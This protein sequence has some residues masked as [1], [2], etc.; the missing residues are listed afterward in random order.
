MLSFQQFSSNVS[1]QPFSAA[2]VVYNRTTYC[3]GGYRVVTF[4]AE[5]VV[6]HI[7]HV[8]DRSR[9]DFFEM[10][11]I[12]HN[13]YFHHRV[14]HN[15]CT[16]KQQVDRFHGKHCKYDVTISSYA[17]SK[18]HIVSFDEDLYLQVNYEIMF[19]FIVRISRVLMVYTC[20]PAF[21]R[22]ATILQCTGLIDNSVADKPRHIPCVTTEN[23]DFRGYI[24]GKKLVTHGE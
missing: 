18:K 24:P 9:W 3:S 4:V 8:M 1:L 14:K 21:P 16:A 11:R 15:E 20:I 5:S 12:V 19:V 10:V 13:S 6:R 22:S 2:T 17:S 7:S 23:G